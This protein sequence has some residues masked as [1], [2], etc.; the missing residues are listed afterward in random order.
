MNEKK[1]QKKVAKMSDYCDVNVSQ[2]HQRDT[3]NS[4]DDEHIYFTISDLNTSSPYQQQSDGDQ[5]QQ[6]AP[7]WSKQ[8]NACWQEYWRWCELNVILICTNHESIVIN[9]E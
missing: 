3:I 8:K 6:S 1:L 4:G 7:D 2:F 9:L 5:T